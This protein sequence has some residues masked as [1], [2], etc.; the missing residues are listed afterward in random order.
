MKHQ[1]KIEMKNLLCQLLGHRWKSSS[2]FFGTSRKCKRCSKKQYLNLTALTHGMQT[3]A[4]WEDG[5]WYAIF[6]FKILVAELIWI[7][8]NDIFATF[9]L[10]VVQRCWIRNT[11]RRFYVAGFSYVLR[12]VSL[13]EIR[14]NMAKVVNAFTS[15]FHR[16]LDYSQGCIS[17]RPFLFGRINLRQVSDSF[18]N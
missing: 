4:T 7:N 17:M 5:V 8:S 15:V 16:K 6:Y 12:K 13:V 18:R 3:P 10:T 2:G 9:T 11:A 1:N 14:R